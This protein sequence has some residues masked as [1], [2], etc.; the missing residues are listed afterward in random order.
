MA[1]CKTDFL[2]TLEVKKVGLVNLSAEEIIIYFVKFYSSKY[3][4]QHCLSLVIMLFFC[5]GLKINIKFDE[6]ELLLVM[7][8]YSTYLNA[9]FL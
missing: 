7:N 5:T 6:T 1:S 3:N 2:G 4:L 8:D 9:D